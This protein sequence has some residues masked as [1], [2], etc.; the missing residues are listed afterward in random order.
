MS[1]GLTAKDFHPRILELY[2]ALAHGRITREAFLRDAAPHV[3][4]G[5]SAEALLD[6]LAPDY[7]AAP[8]V[9]PDDPAIRTARID[10]RSPEGHRTVSALLA[11]P[12]EADGPRPGVLVIHE[13]RGLNPYIEDVARRLAKAGY[14]AL[15]PDG[16]SAE[17]GYPGN[18]DDGREMQAALDQDKLRADFCA[19]Y[20]V[21]RDHA[22]TTSRTGALGFCWGGAMVNTLAVRYPDLSAGVAF[23]GRQ[24][25]PA[26][27]PRIEAPLLL[28]YAE[29]DEKVNAGWPAY[30]AALKEHGKTYEAV[31]HPG[32]QHAFHNDTTP[33]YDAVAAERAWAQTLDFFA[34]HLTE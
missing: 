8:Q 12:A 33:R 27:V 3:A 29:A 13:N 26:D 30:E 28:H 24:P 16:L 9:A 4:E 7:G 20:E 1:T 5:G 15:A 19:G 2:D 17:G 34:R 18:D 21:L 14:I 23:Y 11:R 22:D 31:M 10:Y 32:V 25:D 6:S